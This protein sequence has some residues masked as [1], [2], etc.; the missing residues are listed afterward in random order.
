[1]I[2]AEASREQEYG[3]CQPSR[4]QTKLT[5]VILGRADT[6][7]FSRR[8]HVRLLRF[9]KATFQRFVRILRPPLNKRG[10]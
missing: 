2:N 3:I 10:E 4:N 9:W 5:D 8:R 7:G 6:A 1:M